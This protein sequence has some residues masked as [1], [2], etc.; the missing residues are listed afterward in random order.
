MKNL[1]EYFINPIFVGMLYEIR[2]ERLPLKPKFTACIHL[3]HGG[4]ERM[5]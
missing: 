1:V 3:P 4:T 2:A 5:D